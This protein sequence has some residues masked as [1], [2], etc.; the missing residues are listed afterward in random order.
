MTGKRLLIIAIFLIVIAAAAGSY[1]KFFKTEENGLEVETGPVERMSIVETVTA[2]G[3]IQ[4]ETQVNISADVSG[5]IIRLEVE[6]GD[7]VEKGQLLL[8]LDRERHSAVVESSEA[9]LRMSQSNSRVT[10]ENLNKAEKDLVR[11][12]ELFD[13]DL[14]TQAQLDAAEA[15][16][17]AD[18]ARYQSALNQVEQVR[19][20]LKQ[21]TDDLSKTRIYSPMSGTISQLNKE[22]GE[23]AVGSQFQSDVIMVLSNLSGMEALVDVDEN[24]IVSVSL[25]DTATIEV[26]ALPDSE[27]KG[28]VTEI[29][30]SAKVSGQGTTDQRTE[31]EVKITVIDPVTELRPGMTCSCDVVTETREAALGVPI[32]CVAV[33]PLEQ[34]ESPAVAEGGDANSADG[35]EWNP[36]KDG[37]VEIVWVFS[38]GKAHARQVKTGIQSDTH[39]E[40]IEGLEEGDEVV[41]GSYRA[42]SRDLQHGIEVVVG[43]PEAPAGD[44]TTEE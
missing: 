22:V 23:I 15:A 31:F 6:E 28:V 13:Q 12:R 39:I 24:D 42:I 10:L 34:L 5:K 9:N 44:E 25:A 41:T 27:A 30:S 14:E 36:D 3:R 29:A 40:I 37:F 8:E 32:Q 18:K 17:Q 35:A 1:F 4:P 33:R 20:G 38:G 11:I 19:A 16:Y 2:T 26:D 21:S 43:E 7:R